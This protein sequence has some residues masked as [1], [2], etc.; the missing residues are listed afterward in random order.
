[1]IL[2]GAL[3]LIYASSQVSFTANWVPW[4][5]GGSFLLTGIV[6]ALS[7]HSLELNCL[8]RTWCEKRQFLG[9][10][11]AQ[12]QGRF[13]DFRGL[14]LSKF[15]RS[16]L[17]YPPR[18]WVVSLEFRDKLDFYDLFWSFNEEKAR[19]RM[20]ELASRM[21]VEGREQPQD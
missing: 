4:I 7:R 14:V 18:F 13:S 9:W 11:I 6:Y 5:V 21:G 3:L 20:Q 16:S 2:L 15:R 8:E 1:M 17:T 10:T 12:K 19:S